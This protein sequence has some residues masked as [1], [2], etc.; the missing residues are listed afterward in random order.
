M[1]Q[2]QNEPLIVPNKKTWAYGQFT[3]Q[4]NDFQVRGLSPKGLATL[5][6]S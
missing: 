4:N 2:G 6:P 5:M 3:L 1:S